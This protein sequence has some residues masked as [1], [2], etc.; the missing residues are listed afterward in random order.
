MSHRASIRIL[1][2][3]FQFKYKL[4][5]RERGGKDMSRFAV[6]KACYDLRDPANVELLSE[7][8]DTYL[9]RYDLTAP[10]R[11]AIRDGD[12]GTLYAMDVAQGALGALM[13]AHDDDMATFVTK[14]RTTLGIPLDENQLEILRARAGGR[15]RFT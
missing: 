7:S 11:E 8:P 13:R 10:E 5:N 14:V 2:A 3:N 6:E 1:Y 9:G 12:I 4:V 15:K